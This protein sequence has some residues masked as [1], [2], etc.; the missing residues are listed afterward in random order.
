MSA[1]AFAARLA[2]S[3]LSSCRSPLVVPRGVVGCA[4]RV[5][6]S[7][8]SLVAPFRSPATRGFVSARAGVGIRSAVSAAGTPEKQRLVFLGTPDVAASALEAILDAAAEPDALFEVHAVVSQPG[9]PRGR[10]RSKSAD[11]PPPPSPVAAAALARGVPPERVLCP[12]K[13]NEEDFLERLRD[14]RPDLCVTAAYG[15]FLPT[16]FLDVPRLGT[17]NIHPSLLPEFRGAAPVQR[18]LERGVERTGVTVAYTVLE[19]DAGPVAARSVRELKGDEKHLDL[20]AELFETGAKLLIDLLPDVWSGRISMTQNSTPQLEFGEPTHAPKVDAKEGALAFTDP[21]QSAKTIVD[22]TR[23]FAGWPGCKGTF[24][25]KP[26]DAGEDEWKEVTLKIV[27][28]RV[29]EGEEGNAGKDFSPMCELS[30]KY[31]SVP[32]AG[33]GWVDVLELQPPGKKAMDAA[34]YLNGIKGSVLRV[35]K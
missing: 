21:T 3:C 17:L 15:N 32:C 30:K 1:V 28:A 10:G 24:E 11:T 27:T 19:M 6:S 14:L 25:V 16:K 9:K 26:A 23:G 12:A 18:A 4:A 2:P 20:L 31:F 35:A 22:K 33:G 29:G 13:A 34:S 5:A 8:C 7:S